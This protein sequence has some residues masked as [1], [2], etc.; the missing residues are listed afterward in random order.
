MNPETIVRGR[1][2][3]A[4]ALACQ[5]LARDFAE[6]PGNHPQAITLAHLLLAMFYLRQTAESP[7]SIHKV[8]EFLEQMRMGSFLDQIEAALKEITP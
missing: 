4:T 8:I 3:E 7:P 5:I 2:K 6:F 1:L